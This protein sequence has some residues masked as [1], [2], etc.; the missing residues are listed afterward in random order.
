MCVC[1]CVCVCV[2]LQI[3]LLFLRHVIYICRQMYTNALTG[4]VPTEFGN[5]Q[6]LEVL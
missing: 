4:T 3:I 1:V 6:E 5:L 2:L